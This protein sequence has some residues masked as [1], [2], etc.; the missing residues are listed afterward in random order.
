MLKILQKI[1]LRTRTRDYVEWNDYKNKIDFLDTFNWQQ[2]V[3]KQN[4][5]NLKPI[6]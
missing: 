6:F 4:I 3:R 2:S 1:K 5:K